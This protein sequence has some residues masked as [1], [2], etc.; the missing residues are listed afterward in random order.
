[1]STAGPNS[2]GTMADSDAV[3]TMAW[4]YPD[5]AM[6]SDNNRAV[7]SSTG[8]D[9]P[10][11]SHYLKATNFG[12]TIPAGAAINGIMVE[13]EK[14]GGGATSSVDSAV[15]IIKADG[16]LGTENKASGDYWP[17]TDTYIAHGAVDNLWSEA[18]SAANIN[19]IDFGV[20]LSVVHSQN[21]GGSSIDHI[22]ITITYTEAAGIK[23]PVLM[24]QYRQRH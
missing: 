20:A 12:F 3:G 17:T 24:H 10:F 22:R 8:F 23:M 16:A 15:R 21:F 14:R 6:A 5:N 9:V 13:F 2:P 4:S 18:W 1:M 19:D 7:V 11:T